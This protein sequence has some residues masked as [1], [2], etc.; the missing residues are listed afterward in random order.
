MPESSGL[1]VAGVLVTVALG[2]FFILGSR[3]VYLAVFP[4]LI[5]AEFQID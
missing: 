3:M 5:A 1:R 4:Q 2:W